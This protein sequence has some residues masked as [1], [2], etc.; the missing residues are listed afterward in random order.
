LADGLLNWTK[1]DLIGGILREIQRYKNSRYAITEVPE[2]K[3]W[4][5]LTDS[6][7]IR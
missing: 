1:F 4:A 3:V 7:A 2:I 6:Q 5:S